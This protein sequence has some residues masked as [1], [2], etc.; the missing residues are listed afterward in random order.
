MPKYL[1][2]PMVI[3]LSPFRKNIFKGSEKKSSKGIQEFFLEN[4]IHKSS[5]STRQVVTLAPRLMGEKCWC[6]GT[7]ISHLAQY[8]NAKKHDHNL[9]ICINYCIDK[10]II[11]NISA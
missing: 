1:F 5:R 11:N 4:P 3:Q 10:N 9:A 8:E 2:F 7:K 6:R